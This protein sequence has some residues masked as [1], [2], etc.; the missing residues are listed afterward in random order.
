M[1][2][3]LDPPEKQ[4]AQIWPHT[5][6][7]QTFL[8]RLSERFSVMEVEDDAPPIEFSETR[9]RRQDMWQL[10]LTLHF[11]AWMAVNAGMW[12][13]WLAEAS[14]ACTTTRSCLKIDGTPFAAWFMLVTGVIVGTHALF[15]HMIVIRDAAI[16]SEV[17]RHASFTSGG[18]GGASEIPS[19]EMP[20]AKS[21]AFFRVRA[22]RGGTC[23]LA[24]ALMLNAFLCAAPPCCLPPC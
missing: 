17:K 22:R 7:P 21:R 20:M 5:A 2:S 18:N 24:G 6:P 16:E 1:R 12:I 8:E 15:H 10:L 11:C 23:I 19:S 13:A 4:T 3:E 14:A 9:S